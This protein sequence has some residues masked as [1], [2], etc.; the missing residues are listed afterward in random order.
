VSRASI[1]VIVPLHNLRNLVGRALDSIYAQTAPPKEI[2]V[3]D[4]GS[5]DGGG[6]FVEN[7]YPE[8]RVLRQE[9]RG[10]A[11]ARN[12]GIKASTCAY[13]CFLDADDTWLPH[14]LEVLSSLVENYTARIAA[15]GRNHVDESGQFLRAVGPSHEGLHFIIPALL[16]WNFL[17]S[18]ATLVQKGLLEELG[19]F[20]ESLPVCEDLDCWLRIGLREQFALTPQPV[21]NY[22]ERTSPERLT[23]RRHLFPGALRATM[24]KFLAGL[25]G[26]LAPE[27]ERLRPILR[28]ECWN[29][30]SKT[31][32]EE[33]DVGERR[34]ALMQAVKAAPCWPPAYGRLL[35]GLLN[36]PVAGHPKLRNVA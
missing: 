31:Y 4:D 26:P 33:G 22:T 25:D 34:L 1:S 32:A 11:S 36:L 9:N 15:A 10:L 17:S 6:D 23:N 14:C 12:T 27:L 16:R 19:F 7:S 29:T 28:A 2:I 30:I 35:K 20:D 8:V 3:V 5:T 18:T 21:T 13:V 24:R